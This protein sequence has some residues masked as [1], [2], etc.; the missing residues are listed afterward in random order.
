MRINR[1]HSKLV[2][3]RK[4]GVREMHQSKRL[5]I[6]NGCAHATQSNCLTL[7][8]QIIR[9]IQAFRAIDIMVDASMEPTESTVQPLN[10]TYIQTSV[11]NEDFT[12]DGSDEFCGLSDDEED[13]GTDRIENQKDNSRLSVRHYLGKMDIECS[14]CGALHWIDERTNKS[15]KKN[16]IFSRCFRKGKVILPALLEPPQEL[17]DLLEGDVAE[18]RFFRDHI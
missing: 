10:S 16:P 6:P 17:M 14:S 2:F 3:R 9:G 4:L 15:S 7:L 13:V 18:S 8:A 12:S 11:A 5:A 1:L